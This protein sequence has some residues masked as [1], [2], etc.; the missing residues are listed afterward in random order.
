MPLGSTRDVEASFQSTL[1]LGGRGL[2]SITRVTKR[3]NA[4]SLFIDTNDGERSVAKLD[5]D[6][7]ELKLYGNTRVHPFAKLELSKNGAQNLRRELR[8]NFDIEKK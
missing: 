7:H 2:D 4:Y 5:M 3:D 1:L 8:D 6:S